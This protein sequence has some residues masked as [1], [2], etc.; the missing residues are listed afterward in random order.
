MEKER[1]FHYTSILRE[2]V[3]MKCSEWVNTIFYKQILRAK[4]RKDG[5]IEN[6][7][8]EI[9][10]DRNTERLKNNKKE[11]QK[12]GKTKRQKDKKTGRRKD[13]NTERHKY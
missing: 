10:N 9:M 5:K 2:L 6:G 1:C 12:D 3:C 4:T 11:R 13:G 8:M 7:K